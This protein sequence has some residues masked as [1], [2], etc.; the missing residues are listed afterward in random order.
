MNA[1]NHSAK[2][3]F[4]THFYTPLI[5]MFIQV[6]HKCQGF[7]HPL[8]LVSVGI[9]IS[10]YIS[11][12]AFLW[13]GLPHLCS[14]ELMRDLTGHKI[15]CSTKFQNFC[16]WG[17]SQ[18]PWPNCGCPRAWE[19]IACEGWTILKLS[20]VRSGIL[21]GLLTKLESVLK[22]SSCHPQQQSWRHIYCQLRKCYIH[23]MSSEY[24]V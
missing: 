23:L 11:Q 1:T 9:R 17:Q 13:W 6:S 19:V 3:L 8:I 14:F 7:D 18:H 12:P 16:L 2:L 5:T 15:N 22:N 10:M 20:V 4:F 21:W 24:L